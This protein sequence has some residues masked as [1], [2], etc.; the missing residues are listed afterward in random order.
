MRIT[1]LRNWNRNYERNYVQTNRVTSVLEHNVARCI[2][3]FHRFIA[4][5]AADRF[6][7]ARRNSNK[8]KEKAC[9]YSLIRSAAVSKFHATFFLFVFLLRGRVAKLVIWKIKTNSVCYRRSVSEWTFDPQIK[10][11]DIALFTFL[12]IWSF[13]KR[14]L[15]RSL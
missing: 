11:P 5:S 1:F 6:I 9:S 12:C 14:S 7:A 2:M 4:V 15:R 8:S 13:A 10:L 3:H